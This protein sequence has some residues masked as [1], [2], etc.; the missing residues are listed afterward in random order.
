[1]KH[2]QLDLE[3]GYK[4]RFVGRHRVRPKKGVIVI[5][6]SRDADIRLVGDDI[7]PIH[8][9]IEFAE[10]HWIVSDAGTEH[11]TWINKKPIMN[12]KVTE[13]TTVMI[14]GH[15]LKLTPQ[16]VEKEVFTESRLKSNESV[17]D[18]AY[19]QVIIRKGNR[20]IRSELLPV[21]GT[22]NFKFDNQVHKLPSPKGQD[23]VT[24]AF[25]AYTVVQRLVRTSQVKI[26]AKDFFY[27]ITS[28]EMR[29]PVGVSVG[30]ILLFIGLVVAVPHRPN[31]SLE[32]IQ[33]DNKYTRMIYDAELVKKRREQ[34]KEMRK[35]IM[36]KAPANQQN[37]VPQKQTMQTPNASPN[38]TPKVVSKLKLEGLNALIGK[39]SK[40]AN[41]NGPMIAAFGRA[42]DSAGTSGITTVAAVGSLQGI[43]TKAGSSGQT[44]KVGGVGTAGKGGGAS[45]GGVGGLATGGAG[46]GTVG[47][48][49][50]ETEIEGGLDKEVIARVIANYMGEIRYCYERQLSAEPDIYGKVQLRFTI[51]GS[52]NVT[53]QRV[54]TTTLN[55]AMVEGC[56]LRRLARWKFPKP[57]GGTQVLVSYPI[58]FKATN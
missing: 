30:L 50:E 18:H 22:F 29:V 10:D 31:D 38:K 23:P 52:G 3:H 51:D 14:G 7:N 2:Y 54:G 27:H 47:I 26:T 19:Q 41:T 40:R 5:G 25:G 21:D 44:Y 37:Q 36:A 35:T 16:M 17:G 28:P 58:M 24:H 45:V 34:S 13:V 12:E 6:S 4:N 53:E 15:S 42:P 55:S 20:T 49:D 32:E 33:P 9:Y 39:I 56:I 57:K 48:L 43:A 1:M 11:G 46:T 8:A